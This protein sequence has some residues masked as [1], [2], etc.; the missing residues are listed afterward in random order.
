MTKRL[1]TRRYYK[2]IDSKFSGIVGKF[3]KKENRILLNS[4]KI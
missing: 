3:C 1:N 4:V 2:I